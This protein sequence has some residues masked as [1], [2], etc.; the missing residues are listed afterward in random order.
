VDGDD[1][2]L[3]GLPPELALL[4][5]LDRP[6]VV[7]AAAAGVSPVRALDLA[8]R[9]HLAGRLASALEQATTVTSEHPVPPTALLDEACTDRRRTA[10]VF[11]TER[12]PQIDHVCELLL[13]AGVRPTLLKG[14]ALVLGG[15]LRAGERPMADVDV[16]VARDDVATAQR[17]LAAGGYRPR[18][19]PATRAWARTRHYQDAPLFH[20]DHPASLDLHWALVPPHDR[21][22]FR[23]ELLHRT[24]LREV[25][26]GEVDRLAD[27]DLVLHLALHQWR[28]RAEGRPGALGQLWDV[29]VVTRRLDEEAWR[30]VATRAHSTGVLGPVAAVLA[31]THLLLGQPLPPALPAAGILAEDPRL[32]AYGTTRVLVPRPEHVQL[33]MVT[34]DVAYRPWRQVTRVLSLL[35]R[36][37]SRLAANHG[38]PPGWQRRAR[39]L[40]RVAR[41]LARA[42]GSPRS[43]R[44]EL[45]LDRWA[46]EL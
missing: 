13:A 39:H 38:H 34:G 46:H 37:T 40:G 36:P 1:A 26:A 30:E 29:A 14:A 6:Q 5:G 35:R 32:H 9:H 3:L 10:E 18:V 45:R 17:A 23:P 22:A 8:R 43:T 28:D 27:P 2:L 15:F 7:R 33:L 12:R 41:L 25:R 11:L 21:R 44:R 31:L 4:L 20:P 42:A 24:R 19:D 16:L